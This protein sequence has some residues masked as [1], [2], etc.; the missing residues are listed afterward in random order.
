MQPSAPTPYKAT[1]MIV[2]D[3]PWLRRNFERILAEDHYRVVP[4]GRGREALATAL[5]VRPDIILL[6]VLMPDMNG[7]EAL[8]QLRAADV[9]AVVVIMT[10]V[11]DIR[12]ARQAMKLGADDL[13]TKPF[14]LD[15][16]RVVLLDA[17]AS[18]CAATGEVEC[19]H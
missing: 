13:I 19:A 14:D 1:L 6:D 9:R 18:R 16:F 11:A 12:V 3:E 5:A 17:L 4:V 7:L 10:A 15:V 8:R 2:D